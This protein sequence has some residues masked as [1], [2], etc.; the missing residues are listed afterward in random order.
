MDRRPRSH[1]DT[2]ELV[3]DVARLTPRDGH[4]RRILFEL[5]AHPHLSQ[6]S[7]SA[8]LGIAL[9]LTNLLIRRL[10][11]RGW[12]Q[13]VRVRPNRL[14]YLLTPSGLAQK[15]RM[16]R[17]YLRER[18]HVYAEARERIRRALGALAGNVADG[19][20]DGVR[21]VFWGSGPA[22]EIGYICLQDSGLRL[23]GVVDDDRV[24]RQFFGHPIHGSP[25]L[26]GH[27]LD[28]QPFD[29]VVVI[30]LDEPGAVTRQLQAAGVDL[31]R[32]FWV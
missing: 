3:S 27:T 32:V 23:V 8:R 24:G 11:A 12:I 26:Q 28:G 29:R 6:R 15:A 16:S 10:V 5:E 21:V 1:V 13:V 9:G 22:A 4:I 14:G 20:S 19:G 30:S 7:L 17:D 25:G 2:V 18:V 31:N